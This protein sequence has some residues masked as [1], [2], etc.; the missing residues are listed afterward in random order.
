[1]RI[2]M[3]LTEFFSVESRDS[4]S[5]TPAIL[6]TIENIK[7]D[8]RNENKFTST[9]LHLLSMKLIFYVLNK[10]SRERMYLFKMAVI[11]MFYGI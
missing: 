2:S 4:P 5:S 6:K 11:V 10:T 9:F 7:N 8:G 1:M 3:G